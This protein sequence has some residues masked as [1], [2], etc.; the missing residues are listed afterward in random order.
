MDAEPGGVDELG[1]HFINGRDGPL[2][3]PFLSARPANRRTYYRCVTGKFLQK[4]ISA[5]GARRASQSSA[6]HAELAKVFAPKVRQ[7]LRSGRFARRHRAVGAVHNTAP[8]RKFSG[9]A[10]LVR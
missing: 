10:V 7:K 1:D 5:F 9:L 3:R 8:S 6:L 2:G 4:V